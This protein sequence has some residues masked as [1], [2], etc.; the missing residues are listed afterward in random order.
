MEFVS[1][2]EA[3]D[4][5]RRLGVVD[6]HRTESELRLELVDSEDVV[7]LHLVPGGAAGGVGDA[8]TRSGATVIDV[9]KP[10]LPDV[11]DHLVHKLGL[12]QLF[13]VPIGKWRRVFDAVAFSLAS[14][15]HWQEIDSTASVS[16]NTRDPLLCEPQDF[17]MMRDLIAAILSD[18]EQPD[19][20]LMITSTKSPF[21]VE[22]HPDGT[23]RVTVG[24]AAVADEIVRMFAS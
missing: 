10:R 17:R 23:A 24:G 15:A 21:M 8:A 4:V 11:I 18:A 20:G 16:L 2:D 1:Y 22:L 5:L 3:M 7:H 12:K 9:A 13:L 19:Q 6:T 14:N